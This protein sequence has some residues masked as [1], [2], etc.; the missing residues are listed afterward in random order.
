MFVVVAAWSDF[1]TLWFVDSP[2]QAQQHVLSSDA[3]EAAA[4]IEGRLQLG[5]KLSDIVHNKE[6]LLALLNLYRNEGY[7]L[8]EQEGKFCVSQLAP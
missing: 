6:D 4:E 5:S 8:A 3:K 1:C 2:L 7:I